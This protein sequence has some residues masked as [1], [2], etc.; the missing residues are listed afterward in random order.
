MEDKANEAKGGRFVLNRAWGWIRTK[1]MPLIGLAL[2]IAIIVGVSILYLKNKDLFKNLEGYGYAG[3][4]VISVAF[5]ATIL[6]PVNNIAVIIALG[7]APSLSPVFV[8]LAGG[9]GAGI[10]EMTGYLAGRSGRGLLKKSDIYN[11]VERW[12]GKWG[13]IAIFILSI[14]PLF[15]DVVGI[16]AGATRMP[17]WKFFLASWL[18]RTL[19][20]V[21]VALLAHWGIQA[22]PSWFS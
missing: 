9:I 8:G 14:F 13:W 17:V 7:A 12:V 21:T 22:I 15:F 1:K 3:A 19:A 4:F 6:I 10:G 5:N 20:Y 11:K 16:I 2:M 18:G